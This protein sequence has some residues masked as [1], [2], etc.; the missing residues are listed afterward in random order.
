MANIVKNTSGKSRAKVTSVT[1]K[2][3]A[4]EQEV[5]TRGGVVHLQTGAKPIPVQ[6]GTPT[7]KPKVPKFS[8]ESLKKLQAAN[9]LSDKTL[10]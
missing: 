4:E 6:I 5:S 2:T 9:N 7:V 8:H 10:L 1:L 3:I